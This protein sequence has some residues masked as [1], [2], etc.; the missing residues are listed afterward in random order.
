MDTST[1]Y[2]H[3]K[4]LVAIVDQFGGA[5]GQHPCLIA[6]E[7]ELLTGYSVNIRAAH[8]PSILARVQANAR[9]KYLA[10]LFLSNTCKERY[11]AAVDDLHNDYLKGHRTTYPQSLD[12]AYAFLDDVRMPKTPKSAPAASFAQEF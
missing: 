4:H 8:D 2:H 12:E 10:C 5:I 7:M 11:G 6:N 9:N 3:I 1:Y